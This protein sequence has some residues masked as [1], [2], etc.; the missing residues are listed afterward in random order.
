M[1][2]TID[3]E[4]KSYKADLSKPIDISIPISTNENP[5][6]WYLDMPKIEPVVIDGWVGS[7]KEGAVVNFNNIAFNPHAHGTHTE[8]I[9]HIT[10]KVYNIN[11]QLKNFFFL[12]EVITVAPEINGEDKIISLKQL[13]YLLNGKSPKAV[14]IR[15][16]PN[17]REKKTRKW[18]HT[19]WPFI[20]EAAAIYLRDC[21]IEHLLVDLPSVDA[22]ED[23]GAVKA[24]KAFWD[25]SG[26]PRLQATITE[27]I[28][29]PHVVKDGSYLLNLQVAAFENDAAPSRPVLYAIKPIP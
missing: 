25:V 15:T 11:N 17:M 5:I 13:K 24:H 10:E 6:A 8:S 9:G 1:N 14:V 18:S 2:I 23:G 16:I 12:A 7:V 4:S 29:V 26:K 22:E 21:G 3:F 20:E 19:H 27:M 28:Y